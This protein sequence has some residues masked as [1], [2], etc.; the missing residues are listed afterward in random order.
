MLFNN[1]FHTNYNFEYFECILNLIELL[2]INFLNYQYYVIG[3]IVTDKPCWKG[4]SIKYVCRYEKNGAW[5][6][7][8][9]GLNVPY[10]VK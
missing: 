4:V 3:N 2:L 6:S 8:R 7:R 9:K 10:E 1:M 5:I